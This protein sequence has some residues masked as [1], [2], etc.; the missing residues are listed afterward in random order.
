MLHYIL[1]ISTITCFKFNRTL[2][3]SL[4]GYTVNSDMFAHV[5]FF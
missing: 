5:P 2:I 3:A 4:N 1:L